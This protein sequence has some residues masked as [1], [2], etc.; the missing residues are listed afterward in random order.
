MKFYI[1]LIPLFFISCKKEK[2]NIEILNSDINIITTKLEENNS[3]TKVEKYVFNNAYFQGQDEYDFS[4][5]SEKEAIE[6]FKDLK[7][8]LTS[9]NIISIDDNKSSFKIEKRSSKDFFKDEKSYKYYLKIFK[10]FFNFN[11]ENKI[12]YLQLDSN[13]SDSQSLDKYLFKEKRVIINENYLFLIY[14]K[15]IICFEKDNINKIWDSKYCE[16]PFDYEVLDRLCQRDIRDKY[17]KLCDK[18]YPIFYFKNNSDIKSIIQKRIPHKNL[19]YYY[20]IKSNFKDFDIIVVVCEHQE[21]SYGDQFIITLKDNKIISLISDS[22]NDFFHSM[23]FFIDKDLKVTFYE[24]NGRSPKEKIINTYQIIN[25]G[26]FK[27]I[28][29]NSNSYSFIKIGKIVYPKVDTYLNI[30]STPNSEGNVI[31]KAYSTDAL[32]VIEV[33]DNWLKVS[34]NGKEG[35]VSSEYVKETP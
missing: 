23:N 31:G 16:L 3:N 1:Y 2:R 4:E 20:N 15:H 5:I 25:D 11:V 8:S 32:K 34:L 6:K 21:E 22:K 14:E 26:S 17:S 28:K 12:N 24:N 19:L 18:K 9:N 29:G 7:I 10:N 27:E 30:R 33:L 35:Y 13:S